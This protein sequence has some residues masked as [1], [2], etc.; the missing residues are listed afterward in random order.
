MGYLLLVLLIALVGRILLLASGSVSFHSDESVVA[1]MARHILQGERPVFFYGQAY[2]GSLDAWLVAVGFAILGESVMTIRIVQSILYLLI[3]ATGFTVALR[4]TGRTAVA[5]IAGLL[6]AI[7]NT[8]VALYTTATLGGYNETLLIGNLI[9]LIGFDAIRELSEKR[10]PTLWRWAALGGL[11]G[12]GWWANGLVIAY[13]LPVGVL[14]LY[15][16][17][18][19]GQPLLRFILP[20]LAALVLFFVG[21]APWW[22]FN[23]ENDFAALRFYLPGG[24]PLSFAGGDVSPLTSEQ[25]LVGLFLLGMPAVIGLRYPWTPLYFAPNAL[26]TVLAVLT[27]AIYLA[28]GYMLIRRGMGRPRRGVRADGLMDDARA[29]L[30]VGIGLFSLTFVFSRFSADPTGRY[31]LPLI[32]FFSVML[33]VWAMSLPGTW[34]RAGVVGVVLVYNTIGLGMAVANTP[35]GVT[36]QFNLDTHLPNDDDN[37]L[38]AFL[39]DHGLTHGYTDYWI[40]Y[41]MAFESG[42]RLIYRAALP[43]KPDLT[44]TPRDDRYTPFVDAV[45]A[46][47]ANGEP[48]AYIT[49]NVAEVQAWLETWFAAQGVTYTHEQVGIFHVYYDFSPRVPVP[50]EQFAGILRSGFQIQYIT[51]LTFL[52]QAR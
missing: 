1:L 25:R 37:A 13:A 29:L 4:L 15:R 20:A 52:G 48:M 7:P 46:A 10:A 12:V 32:A 27:L 21:S 34:I 41:R 43:Y 47:Q 11:A 30:L 31:F 6:L 28:A 8:L 22:V 5:L 33:A 14:M 40:A 49:A 26:V 9:L 38:I 44:Y 19:S 51:D 45:N 2:M 39:E 24:T 23:F 16:A 3:V 35:P 42:E 18:R 36:T 50:P 17:A